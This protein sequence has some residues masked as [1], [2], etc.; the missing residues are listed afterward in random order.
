M[1]IRLT[2]IFVYETRRPTNSTLEETVRKSAT[3]LFMPRAK[4]I[5]VSVNLHTL[6]LIGFGFHAPVFLRSILYTPRCIFCLLGARDSSRHSPDSESSCDWHCSSENSRSHLTS[7][8]SY[9]TF[10]FHENIAVTLCGIYS[11]L[12]LLDFL[13][14]AMERKPRID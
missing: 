8:V 1:V 11:A 5:E 10:Y 7:T 2:L 9:S 6:R 12:K 4:G 13:F 14:L 3:S